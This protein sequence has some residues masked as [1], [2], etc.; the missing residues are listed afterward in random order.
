M[1][2]K[3][4]API[5]ANVEKVGKTVLDAAFKVHTALGPGLLESVYETCTAFEI[6]ESGLQVATQ[7]ALPVA[8]KDIQMDAGLRLDMLVENCVIVEFK[9]VEAMN[10]IYEAQLLTYLKLTGIRL[11]FLINFNVVRLKDGIK[12]MII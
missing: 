8:Y 10:P 3:N 5:V 7:V 6:R 12:R 4:Y 1:Q 11:G 2:R 9:S